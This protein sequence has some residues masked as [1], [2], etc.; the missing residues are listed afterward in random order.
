MNKP[1]DAKIYLQKLQNVAYISLGFPLIFFIYGYLESS[2]DQLEGMVP[3]NYLFVVLTIAV[4]I[5]VI[6]ITWSFKK[7]NSFLS[8][9]TEKSQLKE[10]LELYRSANNY[11]FMTYGFIAWLLS[12]SFYVTNHQPLAAIFG[13]LLVLFSIHNPSSRRIVNELQLKKQDKEIILDGLE[14]P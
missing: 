5:S 9:A 12:I 7:Y 14:I 6:S 11:R 4:L 3:D 1:L 2:V 8:Q 13:I 10:K